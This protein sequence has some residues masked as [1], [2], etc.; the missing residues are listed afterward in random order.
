M[1]II[2]YAAI[3]ILLLLLTSCGGGEENVET[4][5]FIEVNTG[6]ARV[7]AVSDEPP[8]YSETTV[9]TVTAAETETAVSETE[10]ITVKVIHFIANDKTKC[11]HLSD[12]CRA[13]K[14]TAQ[15]NLMDLNYSS[16][17]L[18]DLSAQ[19]YWACG[20]CCKK[21]SDKLPK[22]EK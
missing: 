8:P 1:R 3:L 10:E 11:L 4:V 15:E 13:V 9:T 12:T 16:D 14:S 17:S 5:E 20:I 2:R 19:G 7:S 22:P 18:A 21:Y 6:R